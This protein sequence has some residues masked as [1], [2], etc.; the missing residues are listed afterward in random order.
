MKSRERILQ[1]INLE[2]VDHIPLYLRLWD[3][4][5]GVDHIP[6]NWRDQ[7]SRANHLTSLGLD[8]TLLLQPP[9]GYTEDYCVDDSQFLEDVIIEK[10]SDDHSGD[11]VLIKRYITPEGELSQKIKISEDWP[12]G[13][14]I[15]LFNDFNI[16]R[17]IQPLINKKEDIKKLPY[18]LS[19]PTE[20]QRIEFHEQAHK[21]KDAAQKIG[22]A[23][24]GG[25]SALGDS[26]IWLCGIENVL[27]WQ[28]DQP[29]LIEELLDILLNWELTR[30]DYLLDE[31]IDVMVHM[32]WYEGTDFWTPRNFRKLLKPRLAK[33]FKKAHDN[34]VPIRYIIT[35]GWEP[36]IDDLME[37]GIDCLT[38]IDPVQDSIDL[39]HIASSIG[40]K[41]CLMGGINAAVSLTMWKERNIRKAVDD[42]IQI[43]GK[44]NGFILYPVDNIAIEWPWE[45]TEIIIDQW[46]SHWR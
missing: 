20:G 45:K 34:D 18:L 32:A 11:I 4:G 8:D 1:S 13:D 37:I 30:L 38:G 21:I 6:F 23:V 31:G 5:S 33:I 27:Y 29:E 46:K 7:I 44:Q 28:M 10:S 19:G 24:D 17:Y 22:V 40:S 41:I 25:W 12:F 35:K 3:L 16:P 42:A 9:L 15:M 26:V 36:I 43:L 14:D 2:Q 39:N